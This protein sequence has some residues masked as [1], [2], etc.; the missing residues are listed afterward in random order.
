MHQGDNVTFYFWNDTYYVGD[1][2]M[3]FSKEDSASQVP[4]CSASELEDL[5]QESN[6]YDTI[7]DVAGYG[8]RWANDTDRAAGDYWN[9]CSLNGFSCA[10]YN[11]DQC[12]SYN[13]RCGGEVGVNGGDYELPCSGLVSV[14]YITCPAVSV[15]LGSSLG[16]LSYLELVIVTLLTCLFLWWRGENPYHILKANALQLANAYAQEQQK[17]M[18]A[19]V[20]KQITVEAKSLA[21]KVHGNFTSEGKAGQPSESDQM[22][23]LANSAIA[24]KGMAMTVNIPRA[25]VPTPRPAATPTPAPRPAPPRTHFR[26][27][28]YGDVTDVAEC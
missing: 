7:L 1:Y 6:E 21:Q 11:H 8:E 4:K 19:N 17:K 26:E 23:F 22:K 3:V 18:M 14:T 13:P 27:V 28:P 12:G 10:D 9:G 5:C 24:Q 20:Q 16:Y 2:L 25:A 15:T